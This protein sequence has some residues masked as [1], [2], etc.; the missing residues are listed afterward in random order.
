MRETWVQPWAEKS[1]WRRK[2]QPTPIFLPGKSRGQRSLGGCSPWGCKKVE[3]DLATKQQ[4]P[5]WVHLFIHEPNQALILNRWLNASG[6]GDWDCVPVPDHCCALTTWQAGCK[7]LHVE[8]YSP[9]LQG[10]LLSPF[11]VWRQQ[12]AC[13][14]GSSGDVT[15]QWQAVCLPYLWGLGSEQ[16][17]DLLTTGT[18]PCRVQEV[19]EQWIAAAWRSGHAPRDFPCVFWN[20]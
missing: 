1:P 14:G 13:R 4:Q 3:H 19:S 2:C 6:P 12:R 9:L 8:L 15:V 17:A 18:A 5:S 10:L 20:V 16:T 7:M 11:V